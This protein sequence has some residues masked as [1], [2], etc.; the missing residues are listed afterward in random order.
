MKRQVSHWEII[1]GNDMSDKGLESRYIELCI[2][3]KCPLVK[4]VRYHYNQ[5]Y[6]YIICLSN[7]N[8]SEDNSKW[9][10]IS[11][12]NDFRKNPI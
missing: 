7:V 4:D 11:R 5:I 9:N 12:K 1:F 8:D 2:V 10:N 3:I 6:K